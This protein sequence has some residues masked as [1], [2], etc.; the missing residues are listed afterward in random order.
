MRKCREISVI[1]LGG[2]FLFFF[3]F[4]FS[5]LKITP[6]QETG[7]LFFLPGI[8]QY[9]F[10][11]PA[12]QNKND[13]LVIGV[14]LLSGIYGNW[15]FDVPLNTLFSKNFEYN[16]GSF[17]DALPETG[18]I[19]ASAGI[20]IFFASF[21]HEDYTL[22]FSVSERAFSSGKFD[23]EIVRL[24]RDGTKNFFGTSEDFGTA[25][26]NLQQFREIAPALSKRVSEKLSAGVRAKILFGKLYLKTEDINLSVNTDPENK[27]LLIEP[28]GSFYMAGPLEHKRDTIFN[29]SSFA[30]SIS[31]ENYFFRTKNMGIAFDAGII[32]TPA[33]HSEFTLSITDA[34][35][36]GFKNKSFDVD[37]DR[38]VKFKE[39]NLYQSYNKNET[40]WLEPREALKRFVDSMLYIID[41]NFTPERHLSY[42][43]VKL[44]ISGKYRFPGKLTAGIASQLMY[45]DRNISNLLSVYAHSSDE[46]KFQ[47]AGG[48]TLYNF[49]NL[50]PGT[51][52]TYTT[53]K[54]QLYLSTNNISGLFNPGKSKHLNLCFGINLLFKTKQ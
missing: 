43:P 38:A 11:N 17:Y 33:N 31:T 8:P 13:K 19:H 50:M 22:S 12:F 2:K 42:L 36:T 35:F 40:D 32:F 26:V 29:Y 7:S 25:S 48:L 3:I 53:E 14:P 5:I 24:I 28:K 37:F 46:K 1:R 9:S 4:Y 20:T 21:R 18:K 44:N 30:P 52:I 34:G 10:Y 51:G 41:V 47:L 16:I 6:A 54:A 45:Q 27:E 49:K 15:N 23:R 39:N